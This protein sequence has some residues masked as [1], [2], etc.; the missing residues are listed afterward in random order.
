MN[1]GSWPS[2]EYTPP[3]SLDFSDQYNYDALLSGPSLIPDKSHNAAPRN[4]NG[5]GPGPSS[6]FAQHAMTTPYTSPTPTQD[7][8]RNRS[9]LYVSHLPEKS[10]V[11]TQILVKLA[12]H[13]MPP[14]ITKLHLPTYTISKSKLCAKPTPEKSPDTLELHAMLVSTTAMQDPAKRQRAS[15]EAIKFEPQDIPKEDLR[16]S[17]GDTSSSDDDE[18]K[19]LNGAPVQICKGCMER[20]RKRA[21]RKKTKNKEEEEEWLKDEAKRTIVF[22]TQE[23]KEW[24]QA[25]PPKDGENIVKWGP[26][27]NR[28]PKDALQVDLPMRIACY[29]RHQE[30]KMGFQCV[31]IPLIPQLVDVLKCEQSRFHG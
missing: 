11:E 27:D 29:C 2:T 24:Q 6:T 5:F 19:P 7:L 12:L 18:S 8:S 13:P 1:Q 25:P 14:G 20:E 4:L 9:K 28:P 23:V 30:E 31:Y 26:P 16:S 21:G 22:N 3:S 17:S 15:V 10:R